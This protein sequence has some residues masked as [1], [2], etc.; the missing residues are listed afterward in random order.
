MKIISE[1]IS[2]NVYQSLRICWLY[3]TLNAMFR[4][5]QVVIE[6]PL[7]ICIP[8]VYIDDCFD[9][10]CQNGKMNIFPSKIPCLSYKGKSLV[11]SNRGKMSNS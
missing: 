5:V 10:L 8:L 6:E 9:K 3:L 2:W 4:L 11:E 1:I 7:S